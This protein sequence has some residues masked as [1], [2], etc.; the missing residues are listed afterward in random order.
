[1]GAAIYPYYATPLVTLQMNMNILDQMIMTKVFL[2]PSANLKCL[3]FTISHR[4]VQI[5]ELETNIVRF[6][7]IFDGFMDYSST[8]KFRFD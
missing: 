3:I 2:A 6:F 1:M 5:I 7:D 4:T 8:Y